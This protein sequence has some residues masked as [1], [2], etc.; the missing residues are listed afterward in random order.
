V[1]RVPCDGQRAATPS[2]AFAALGTTALVATLD[3]DSLDAARRAV[4]RELAAIDAAC[5]R[6]RSDSELS[7]VNACPGRF[8]EVGDVLCSALEAALDAAVGTDGLVDPT[9]G[10]SLLALGYRH[11]FSSV[12]PSPDAAFRVIPAGSFRDVELDVVSRRVR[13]P[14]GVKLDLGATAKALAA[15][16]SAAAAAHVSSGVLVS[17]GGDIRVAGAAPAPGWP[18]R[19]TE[20][21]RAPTSA[22][23]QTVAISTGGLATSSTTVRRWTRGGVAVHHIVD[24]RSGSPARSI[25]RTVSVAAATCLEANVAA[26]A[27]LVLG[28]SAVPWLAGRALPARLVG[29]EGE[30]VTVG[31]W[32]DA[33]ACSG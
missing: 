28:T 18:V 6:F 33:E 17:L 19:V 25:W 11:D 4:A 27:S 2:V 20:D 26:T 22:C 13:V 7:R 32:P 21:H 24:P 8:V 16:R 23:G 30:I 29:A 9:V 14:L 5:S 31:A 3:A 10:N 12:T 1:T 15:D